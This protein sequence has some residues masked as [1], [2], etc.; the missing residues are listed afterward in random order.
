[1]VNPPARE[2][3]LHDASGE[4]AVRGDEPLAHPALPGFSLALPALFAVLDRPR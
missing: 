4:R 1:M 3:R 2:A